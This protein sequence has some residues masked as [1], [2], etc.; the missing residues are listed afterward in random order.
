MSAMDFVKNAFEYLLRRAPGEAELASFVRQL[1]SGRL[2]QESALDAIVSSDEF[3][4]CILFRGLEQSLHQS[5]MRFVRQMPPADVIVDLGGSA[6]GSDRGAMVEMG[7]P[8]RFESLTIVDLPIDRRH[9]LY[10]DNR[11]IRE[12]L[13]AQGPVRYLYRSMTDLSPFDDESVDLVYSGQS[14][15]HVTAEDAGTALAEVRRILKPEGFLYIDTPNGRITRLQ[16]D[17]FID[18]D[19]EVEYTHT[20]LS[21][22]LASSGFEIVEAKGM[23]YA[24]PVQSRDE[25]DLEAL[26]RRVGLYAEP[27]NCYLLAYVCRRG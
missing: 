23:N 9:E 20:E 11:E 22:L 3:S 16:Q 25:L 14:I 6:Q 19:H 7:Y 17:E 10:R 2:T 13:T 27:Q 26:A 15:E 8:Y 18:P 4:T 12:V 5:R 21:G 1:D 24:G